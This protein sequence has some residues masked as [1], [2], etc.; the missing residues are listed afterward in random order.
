MMYWKKGCKGRCK[1]AVEPWQSP[2]PRAQPIDIETASYALLYLTEGAMI[3]DAMK[4]TKWLT[5]QRNPT[6]GFT[7]SQVLVWILF[8]II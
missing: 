5:S 7:T 1:R 4:V 8:F 6:G 2:N 3:E